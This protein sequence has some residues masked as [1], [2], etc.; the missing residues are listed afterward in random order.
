MFFSKP[1]SDCGIKVS[2]NHFD[3]LNRA[4]QSQIR[5]SQTALPEAIQHAAQTR[6][7]SCSF[8]WNSYHEDSML[9]K[10]AIILTVVS[11]IQAA[12]YF[13]YITTIRE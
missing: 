5:V 13:R 2:V 10:S 3:L 12:F 9:V 1:Q 6:V 7:L 8:D 4:F 11:N